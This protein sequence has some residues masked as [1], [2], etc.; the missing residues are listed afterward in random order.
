[1]AGALTPYR[2]AAA[3][4]DQ[5]IKTDGATPTL[6]I[7]KAFSAFNIG[8]T[9][10]DM[11]GDGGGNGGGRNADALAIVDRAAFDMEDLLAA[12]RDSTA[13]KMLLTL[14]GQQAVLLENMGRLDAALGPLLRGNALRERR[15]AA[16]PGNGAALRDLA[17]GLAQQARVSASA[18]RKA[19]AC[20]LAGRTLLLW[21]TLER[22]DALTPRDAA[23]ERPI[24]EA[25]Q[26][27]NCPR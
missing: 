4:I 11:G 12:G 18:G 26:R 5:R 8:S 27:A 20:T 24:A 25:M 9:L 6:R 23:K 16:H 10:G 13:E 7:A 15:L 3:L 14:Y 21:K 22:Q 1:M 2:E 17:I 19:E